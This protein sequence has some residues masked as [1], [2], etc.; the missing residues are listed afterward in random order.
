MRFESKSF[1][2]LLVF[3]LITVYINGLPLN[4]T[5]S[6]IS[7]ISSASY[8]KNNIAAFNDTTDTF[9]KNCDF[10]NLCGDS[11][12]NEKLTGIISPFN[13][14]IVDISFADTYVELPFP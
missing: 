10:L 12:I 3:V 5:F 4:V 7:S 14:K 13:N 9:D 11:K 1:F 6:E 2:A 8:P